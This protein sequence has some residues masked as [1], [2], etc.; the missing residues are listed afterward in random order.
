MNKKLRILTKNLQKLFDSEI[1][2]RMALKHQFVKRKSKLT[3]ETFL[4]LCT[5]YG[6]DLCS[7]A[8]TKLCTRLSAKDDVVLSPQALHNRFNKGAAEFMKNVFNEM[9]KVQSNILREQE[10]LLKTNFNRITVVDSTIFK[11]PDN[12]K[13]IYKGSISKSGAKI[14]LQYDLLTGEFIL[15]EV[16][17]GYKND[18]SYIPKLQSTVR[19]GDLCL[20]DLGYLKIEDLRFIE[21]KEAYYVSKLKIH[22]NIFKRQEVTEIGFGGKTTVR[23]KYSLKDIYKLTEPLSEG[24]TLEL[25]E[26]YLGNAYKNKFKTRLIVTKLSEENKR[27]RQNK[28]KE[29]IRKG[30]KIICEK[31]D[32]WASINVYVTNTPVETID[33]LKVHELYTLRWHV[34]I[35]FKIWK[36]NF[37]IHRVKKTKIER[38][39]CFLY[40]RLI[41]ILLSLCIVFTSRKAIYEKEGKEISELKSFGI[42]QDY[43]D[44]LRQK[45]FKG[46]ILVS[47]LLL[48]IFNLIR[49]LGLKC[50]RKGRKT[51]ALI[52][53]DIEITEDELV[54]MAS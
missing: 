33:A 51:L 31:N 42:V 40:G 3:G 10:Q 47:S 11:L 46:E 16:M 2:R 5:F 36:S 14:Q 25:P 4:N 12:H 7:A 45:I 24:E 9:M 35:M 1:I 26:I 39:E 44:V 29:D 18:G 50:K 49:K 8:L 32:Q 15:C 6:E 37:K 20:K 17:Q 28:Q 27:K 38:F 54:K 30:H 53:K 19:K 13:K 43:F 41:A 22:M 34:E 52:L 21:N 48:K 23:D